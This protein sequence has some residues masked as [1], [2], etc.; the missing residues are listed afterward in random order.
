[1]ADDSAGLYEWW[2][3]NIPSS[4]R[5]Y[6]QTLFGDRK[7]PF[8]EKDFTPSELKNF[9]ALIQASK[10]RTQNQQPL[11]PNRGDVQYPDYATARK[12][13]Q[14]QTYNPVTRQT[15]GRFVYVTD[16]NTGE[17]R[18]IDNYDFSNP[19]R[20]RAVTE[21]AQMEPFEK[22]LAVAKNSITSTAGEDNSK[23]GLLG[24]IGNAYIGKEGRPVDIKY[25]TKE[26]KK[27]KGGKVKSKNNVEKAIK[28]GKKL[29]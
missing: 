13:G 6:L 9:E 29:I 17:R 20:D 7:Q 11:D 23:S 8:T 16:P 28:G 18:I 15:L 2:K 21:Y 22:A 12:S 24:E 25:N 3:Q 1:M 5:L 19:E 10:L 26:V 4:A 14:L 27:K